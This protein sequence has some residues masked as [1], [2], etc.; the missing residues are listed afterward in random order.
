MG[1]LKLFVS[2]VTTR[3]KDGG[4]PTNTMIGRIAIPSSMIR[5]IKHIFSE[6][7]VNISYLLLQ[8]DGPTEKKTREV[9]Y[10]RR[11]VIG[12]DE[13]ALDHLKSAV[14]I[15][16]LVDAEKLKWSDTR[17][18][19]W[20]YHSQPVRPRREARRWFRVSWVGLHRAC[21]SAKKTSAKETMRF[22]KRP[23]RLWSDNLLSKESLNP[24]SL[25]GLSRLWQ[26]TSVSLS[27][28]G[29]YCSVGRSFGLLATARII[30]LRRRW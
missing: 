22:L 9:R 11:T 30:D 29:Q 5:H 15:V 20:G 4:K 2:S 25:S 17:N 10:T 12:N 13:C 6:T 18:R 19:G 1:F 14:E 21:I 8:L 16:L 28:C 3:W 24:L 23:L 26:E 27:L 7:N